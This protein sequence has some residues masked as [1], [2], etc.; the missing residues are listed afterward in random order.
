MAKVNLRRGFKSDANWYSKAVRD[1]LGLR[2]HDPICPWTLAQHLELSVVK[3]SDYA[4][5][6]P[7]AVAYLHSNKG[8]AEFSAITAD[9]GGKRVIIHNDA[10]ERKRQ[11]ANIA[12]EIAHCL[13]IHNL[14]P[15]T[16]ASG[17]RNYDREIEDEASWL[18]PTLLVPDA[19]ALSIA[20]S[21]GNGKITISEASDEYG[22][23][24]V[25]LKMRLNVSGAMIRASR[26]RAA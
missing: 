14:V 8:Q 5:D 13:L 2:P 7:D 25:L 11:A 18:G 15:L 23:S 9:F 16:A 26:R 24:E 6:E 12:H 22:V 19:A 1:E 20:Y 4:A 10:H 17:A 21:L 3:I